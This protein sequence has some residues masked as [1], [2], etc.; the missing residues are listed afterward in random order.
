MNSSILSKRPSVMRLGLIVGSLVLLLGLFVGLS[1][2]TTYANTVDIKDDAN[3]LSSSDETNLRNQASSLP[4]NVRILTTN[5]YSDKNSF[6]SYVDSNAPSNGVI[7]AVSPNLKT[8]RVAATNNI[9]ITSSEDTSIANT[10]TSAF[11]SSNWASGLSSMLNA[12]RGY[13]NVSSGSTSSSGSYSTSR[14][15]SS[16]FPFLG[17]LVV[18]I[19]ALVAISIFGAGRRR[20]MNN[21]GYGRGG[22]G[23]GPGYNNNYGPG[24]GPNYG[25]GYGGGY[26]YG[27]QGGGIGPLGGGAIGAGLGGLAGYEIGKEVGR[28]EAGGYNNNGGFFGGNS[29][30]SSD[31]GNS[32]GVTGG[33]ADWGGGSGSDSGFGSGGSVDF[34]GGGD[35][36]GG[37]GDSGGGG[38]DSGGGSSW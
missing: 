14:S 36:G 5:S 18:G 17:C 31:W 10:G 15:S 38:G 30:G 9:G 1:V 33:S 8:A 2:R 29:G 37:G 27:N 13:A 12:S 23:P 16:G 25:P 34:G 11:S 28:N 6:T 22:Y 32:G 35:W 7:F 21:T 3:V 26:G 24:Y 20:A 19:I 4:F